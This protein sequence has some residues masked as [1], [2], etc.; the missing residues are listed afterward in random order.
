MRVGFYQTNPAFGEKQK[1]IEQIE[2]AAAHV[3]MD[4]LV[5]PEL[6]TT[7]YQFVSESEVR[8]L[9]EPADGETVRRLR[10]L[11]R[12]SGMAIAAGFLERDGDAIYNSA[13]FVTPDAGTSPAL[14]R[15][16][17]LFDEEKRWMR[18]GD[19]GFRVFEHHGVRMGMLVCFDWVF[20]EA[21][22]ALALEG[23]DLLLHPANLV[24]P[25][26]QD[27]MRTRALENGIFAITANRVGEE[28]REGAPRRLDFTG[29]SQVVGPRGEVVCRAGAGEELRVVE[30][31]PL[32]ARDKLL[33][34][35]NDLLGDRRPDCYRR[36]A[37]PSS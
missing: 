27:A 33:T 29:M 15:K 30:I 16:V 32:R 28:F 11:A 21:A 35:R 31:E 5:L 6:C 7:G 20:P 14:Y 12:T 9:A 10:E 23:M 22:R 18:P 2:T 24:L 13:V 4:L 19:L 25:F 34:P 17:H 1:N 36:L 37:G 26:C 3:K 8:E